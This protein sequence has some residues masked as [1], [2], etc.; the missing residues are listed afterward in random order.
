[1]VNNSP[2]P[3]LSRFFICLLCL[4]PITVQD[5]TTLELIIQSQE[6]GLYI[7]LSHAVTKSGSSNTC[8]KQQG[9]I[10]KVK[11]SHSFA[12]RMIAPSTPNLFFYKEN[13]GF[14]LN[15]LTQT[16]NPATLVN[17]GLLCPWKCVVY[18]KVLEL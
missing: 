13:T 15:F 16:N 2:K 12:G 10:S 4:Y 5:T 8:Q 11:S 7:P 14:P 6:G 17:Q 9:H 18:L 3:N 1:M